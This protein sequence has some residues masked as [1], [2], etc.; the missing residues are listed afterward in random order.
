MFSQ[1]A[2]EA[3]F[4]IGK[5]LLKTHLD[6]ASTHEEMAHRDGVRDEQIVLQKIAKYWNQ[7]NWFD[8]PDGLVVVTTHRVA[9]LAKIKSVTVTTDFLSFPFETI[10]NVQKARVMLVSPAV[11]F[12]AAGK[13][14]VFTLLSG[15]QTVYDAIVQ[16]M[17]QHT[18]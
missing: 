16:G 4:E 18:L 2:G 3:L 6:K 1:A 11:R 5:V 8:R 17:R 15:S 12:E 7:Q 13:E 14:Y 9:F 10:G